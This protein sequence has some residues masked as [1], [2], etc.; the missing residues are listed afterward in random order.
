[1]GDTL[2]I[3]LLGPPKIELNGRP[4]TDLGTRKATALLA[5][6]VCQQRPFPRETLAELLWED[7]DPQQALA[8]LRSLL[9]GMRSKLKPFLI[10]TRHTVAFNHA[11]D[12]WL[13]VAEFNQH[14]EMEDWRLETGQSPVSS[15]QSLQQAAALYCGDFLEGFFVRES[16]GLEEW[17]IL[18]REKLQRQAIKAL[19]QLVDYHQGQGEYAVALDYVNKRIALD[20]LSERANR[21]KMLLLARNG[22][23]NAALRHYEAY[24]NLLATE[25]GV[26]PGQETTALYER[27]LSARTVPPHNLP[28]DPTPFV[29]RTQELTDV[30]QRLMQPGCRLLS[31]LGPGGMGK[32]RLALAAAGQIATA[33]PGLFL[34]GIRYVPL[35]DIG[36]PA[37]LPTAVANACGLE[38]Q[39]ST[40][41]LTQLVAFLRPREMLL[42]LDNFEHLCGPHVGPL[43]GVDVLLT[44]LQEAPDLKLLVTSRTRLHL[45]EEWVFDLSGLH[46]PANDAAEDWTIYSAIQ[47]FQQ[48]ALR[49]RHDFTPQT[50]DFAAIARLCRLLEG[51]PLG[52]ELAAAWVRQFSCAQITEQIQADIA[53]L[54]TRLRNVPARHRS[55]T[56]VFDHS[57]QLLTAT[58]QAIFARLSIFQGGFTAAAAQAVAHA[59]A[60]DLAGL[61]TQS[62]LRAEGNGRFAIH[63]LLRQYAARHLTDFPAEPAQTAVRHAAYYIDFLVSQGDG[64][65]TGQRQAIL[66]ELPNIRLAWEGIARQ[67]QESA[68]LRAAKPLH[69]FYSAQSWFQEGIEAFQFALNQ[70]TVDP[71]PSAERAETICDLLNRKARLHIHIGQLAAARQAL[72]DAMTSLPLVQDPE[73]HA[74]TLGYVAITHFYAGDFH[75][76]AELAAESLRL[77]EASGNA[78]GMAFANNFLGSC[79]KAL[80]DYDQAGTYFR[81]SAAIYRQQQDQLGEAM[82]LNNLGNLAQATG[83]FA[84]AQAYY[85]ECSAL[86]KAINHTHGAATTLANAGRLALKQNDYTQAR[87]LLLE[88]LALKRAQNDE[89]GTAVA[90]VGL[91]GV[92]VAAGEL[93]QAAAELNEALALARQCGDLK[94]TLEAL[95]VQAALKARCGQPDQARQ[96]LAYILGNKATAQEVRDAAEGLLAEVTAVL[97]PAAAA[98]AAAAGAKLNLETAVALAVGGEKR[99]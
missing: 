3:H 34:H 11:S 68:L 31:V 4:L 13:D 37:L 88:S 30:Q 76:A 90:L 20:N 67:Q 21:D 63:E 49:V 32:T 60:A 50:A 99:P 16:R 47:L 61:V 86:F 12:Y 79:H 66:A 18:E 77:A 45:Q 19:R 36:G 23:L 97:S 80:G 54:S 40:D 71:A 81:R 1:M 41:L 55:L 70:F 78:E 22:R 5:Y 69:G 91:G 26:A 57:W 75:R 96:L 58:E 56:A 27:L 85:L 52:I 46:Y 33:N 15:L 87:Q 94:L 74:A 62:L 17:I 29:G 53:F 38:F 9:S 83:D 98:E 73:R 7:R 35:A 84:T 8:N 24:K 93:A 10:I 25:I 82:T 72:A 89:R 28:P 92:S 51:Q 65:E 14:L 44:L 42:V 64:S 2:T 59:S 48:Q 95:N 39:G 6:L 43:D